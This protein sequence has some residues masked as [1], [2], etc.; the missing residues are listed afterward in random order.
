MRACATS[1][2]ASNSRVRS[3]CKPCCAVFQRGD[4]CCPRRAR[5]PEN[6][7]GVGKAV[8]HHPAAAGQRWADDGLHMFAAGGEHQQQVSVSRVAW[9]AGSSSRARRRSPARAASS[10][11]SRASMPC[12]ASRAAIAGRCEFCRR[13]R[14]LQGNRNRP[15]RSVFLAQNIAAHCAVVF[16]QGEEN[17]E[18]HHRLGDKIQRAAIGRVQGGISSAAGQGNRRGRQ[19]GAGVG[20]VQGVGFG[21][22]RG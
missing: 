2:G 22:G 3:G 8:R 1:V 7:G 11:V 13:R 17:C 6:K 21:N 10:R 14:C 5:R 18:L 16:F 9:V 19:A 12:S 15:C 4:A 20:V